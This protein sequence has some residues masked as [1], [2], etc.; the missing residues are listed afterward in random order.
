[1]Y[2]YCRFCHTNP[3]A[4]SLL[5]IVTNIKKIIIPE[6]ILLCKTCTRQKMKKIK[7]KQLIEH[8][9]KPL[10]LILFDVAGL[11]LTSYHRFNYFGEIV[12][13]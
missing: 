3:K 1:M 9:N 6:K 2:Y 10:A 8:K 4:L 13:N 7:S 11:F 5:Y 12:N